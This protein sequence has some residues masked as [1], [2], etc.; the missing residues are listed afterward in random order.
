MS[1]GHQWGIFFCN[2][3]EGMLCAVPTDSKLISVCLLTLQ[4]A[5][6]QHAGAV[7]SPRLCELRRHWAHCG[8]QPPLSY[9]FS[10]SSIPSSPSFPFFPLVAGEFCTYRIPGN[11]GERERDNRRTRGL[12]SDGFFK[13][14]PP[15][16]DLDGRS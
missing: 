2:F 11:R 16:I 14:G 1:E 10:H 13:D 8:A 12:P 6:R 15:D 9:N 7:G 4:H 3:E 5:Y